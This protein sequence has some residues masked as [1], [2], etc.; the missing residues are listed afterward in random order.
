MALGFTPGQVA[1]SV[2]VS[3]AARAG[4]AVVMGVPAGLAV[5]ALMLETVGT[6]AGIG[7]EPGAL[8]ARGAACAEVAEALRAE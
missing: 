1:L 4:A 7:P 2:A 3:T 5:A 6:E 8:A